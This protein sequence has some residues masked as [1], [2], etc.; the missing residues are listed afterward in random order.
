MSLIEGLPT[1]PRRWYGAHILGKV[2]V[3]AGGQIMKMSRAKN[4]A[5]V[6]VLVW[7]LMMGGRR[8]SEDRLT[9]ILT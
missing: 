9:P 4:G 3:V 6:A 8:L 7:G 1:W 5:A 2:A